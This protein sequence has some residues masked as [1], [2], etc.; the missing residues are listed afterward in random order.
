MFKIPIIYIFYKRPD[1]VKKTFLAIKKIRPKILYICQDGPK[2][3]EEKIKVIEA[4]NVVMKMID[5]DCHLIKIFRK[6]NKGL[7]GH[8]PD[9]LDNFFKDN[10][11]GIYIEDDILASDD[12]FK[13]QQELLPK[14]KNDE[15]IY[16]ISGFNPFGDK[17]KLKESYYLSQ[18]SSIWGAG[19]YRRLWKNYNLYHKD[20][21]QVLKD[22]PLFSNKYNFYL[23][24]YIKAINQRKLKTWDLQISYITIKFDKFFIFPR[25]NLVNNIGFNN[26]GTSPFI[27]SYFKPTEN[28]FPIKHPK[29]LGYNPKYDRIYFDN[30]L[31]GGWIRLWLIKIYLNL[32]EKLKALIKN[33]LT[34]LFFIFKKCIKMQSKS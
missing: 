33:F 13:F 2:S 12:F 11:Y 23:K 20:V 22:K 31:R 17:L 18:M 3:E 7:M 19:L 29:K 9:S 27:S 21:E 15:R 8:I 4:R 10:E 26:E 6:E 5:W 24:N 1:L 34:L 16:G 28:I 25:A 30:L 32:P 14:F